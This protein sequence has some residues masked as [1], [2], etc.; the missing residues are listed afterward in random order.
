[1]HHNTPL[2]QRRKT[3]EHL[4]RIIA[5]PSFRGT[6][7]RTEVQIRVFPNASW[8]PFVQ[9][10][11]QARLYCSHTRHIYR[12]FSFAGSYSGTSQTLLPS[13]PT[14]P[15]RDACAVW[16]AYCIFNG[17]AS[18][19]NVLV[20]YFGF[21]DSPLLYTNWRFPRTVNM[22]PWSCVMWSRRCWAVVQRV[23]GN[24]HCHLGGLFPYW[25]ASRTTFHISAPVICSNSHEPHFTYL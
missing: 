9:F 8:L 6:Y 20:I 1:M 11:C 17:T 2:R 15:Q 4:S 18:L 7:H 21:K 16:R 3:S 19:F 5:I 13:S 14:D 12:A 23:N 24:T 22:T 10:T 25:H